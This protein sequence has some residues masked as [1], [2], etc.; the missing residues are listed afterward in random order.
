MGSSIGGVSSVLR[1]NF[2]KCSVAAAQSSADDSA[3]YFVRAS[4][5]ENDVVIFGRNPSGKGDAK[6]GVYSV[7]DSSWAELHERSLTYTTLPCLL[8]EDRLYHFQSACERFQSS[9]ITRSFPLFN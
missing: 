2:T 3:L 8:K 4:G 7:S 6:Q 5:V 1:P 9:Q